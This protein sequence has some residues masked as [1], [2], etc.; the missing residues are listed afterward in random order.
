MSSNIENTTK[1]KQKKQPPDY[2]KVNKT[3]RSRGY[4]FEY[5][6][7][8]AFNNHHTKDWYARRLRF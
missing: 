2:K 7:V 4:N 3:R 6:I 8:Q 1:S 5:D